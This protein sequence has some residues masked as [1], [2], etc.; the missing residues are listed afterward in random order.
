MD[1]GLAALLGA[2]VGVTGTVIAS[3]I[4]GWSTRQ[5][6]RAQAMAE[7]AQWRRQVRRDAYGAFLAPAGESRNALKVAG[8]AFV[9]ERDTEEIDRRLQEAHDQ[10]ALA[11]AAW[12]NLA[13]EGPEPVEQAA[14]SVYTT[15]RSMHTTLLALRDSPT[16]TPDGNARFLERHA[17]EVGRLSERISHFAAVARDALDDV[18]GYA[19]ASTEAR[20]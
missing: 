20:T 9:G 5:Q 14:R 13:I 8:R 17:V 10:L 2:S 15:L 12:A 1:Q 7:H 16:N 4:T 19:V 11:Q 18:G 3:A 6:V